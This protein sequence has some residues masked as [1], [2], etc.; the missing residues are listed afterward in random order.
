MQDLSAQGCDK[1]HLI[2]GSDS[3]KHC[4]PLMITTKLTTITQPAS[5]LPR[6]KVCHICRDINSGGGQCVSGYRPEIKSNCPKSWFI[7]ITSFCGGGQSF[8]LLT[9]HRTEKYYALGK[10]FS[11]WNRTPASLECKL[12]PFSSCHADSIKMCVQR[13]GGGDE[14]SRRTVQMKFSYS[15]IGNKSNQYYQDHIQHHRPPSVLHWFA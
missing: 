1:V 2:I 7:K 13:G 5:Y 11:H 8:Y 4:H 3:Q 6:P 15:V 14:K 10:P 9:F 12:N